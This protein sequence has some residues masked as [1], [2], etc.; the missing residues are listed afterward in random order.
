[1][2][3]F[4]PFQFDASDGRL[5]NTATGVAQTLRPQ[6]ARLLD[7][8]LERQGEVVERESLRNTIWGESAVVDFD[9]GMA[10]LV[11]ELRKAL[12]EVGAEAELVETIPR[13][14][15]RFRKAVPRR[16]LP[17]RTIAAAIAL[18][19]IAG[20][21]TWF[22]LRAPPPPEHDPS[23]L[24]LA[25]LPFERFGD[26]ER[27]PVHADL[28]LPDA[29]LERLWQA[30]LEGLELVGRA[31]LRPYR[32][33]DDIALLVAEDLGVNLLIEGTVVADDDGWRVTARLLH[34]PRGRVLWSQSVA[35]PETGPLP[36][37]ASVDRLIL[38]FQDNFSEIS[39]SF[40]GAA[41]SGGGR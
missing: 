38:D 20:I 2:Y 35:W 33:R 10:A 29:L 18:L 36:V 41:P 24:T 32:G 39:A 3:R 40:H 14:G 11:R 6:V 4:D 26:P 9:A 13:R 1:M 22:G 23:A 19:M 34:M 16:E 15:L 25:I 21:V 17:I 8:L 28:L 12:V 7:A 37:S 31:S 27:E 5:E 30:E